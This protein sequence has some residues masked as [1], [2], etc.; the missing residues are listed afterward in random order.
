MPRSF[1]TSV[2]SIVVCAYFSFTFTERIEAQV[3][4]L[5]NSSAQTG[6]N[7]GTNIGNARTGNQ[8][9]GNSQFGLS[10]F[11]N[12]QSLNPQN[13]FIGRSDSAV[14]S[15]IGRSNT[16]N[17]GN[18]ASQN[19][20]FNRASSSGIQNGQNQFNRG[21][22]GP[23]VPAFRPQMKIAFTAPP[24]P[25]SSVTSSMGQSLDRL[26]ARNERLRGVQFELNADRSITLRGQV[27]SESAK[28]LA[29]FLAMLEP[30]VRK[31]KNELTVAEK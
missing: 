14:D 18:N 16:Q 25:L 29:A 20:N 24:L 13:G 26:K 3:Q 15:F 28:K 9:L 11:G 8:S 2:I 31:V 1:I 27:K 10:T 22:S 4:S 17:T 30:G 6:G 12:A 21:Q 7:T 23:I 5:S 19:R